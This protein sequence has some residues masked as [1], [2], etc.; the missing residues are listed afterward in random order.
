MLP[1]SSPISIRTSFSPDGKW[2]CLAA[3]TSDGR[4]AQVVLVDAVAWAPAKIAILDMIQSAQKD[5][6]PMF[7]PDSSL[8][9]VPKTEGRLIALEVAIQQSR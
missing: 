9:I 2:L 4:G 7:S 3:T 5:P 6:G 8:L 1:I